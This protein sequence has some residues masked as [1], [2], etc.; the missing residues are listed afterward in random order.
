MAAAGVPREHI[1]HVLNHVQGTRVTRIYDRYLYDREKRLAL[2]TWARALTA[3]LEGK[4]S[5]KVVPITTTVA[6]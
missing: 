5:G 2:E 1:A 6:S 4:A 3:I